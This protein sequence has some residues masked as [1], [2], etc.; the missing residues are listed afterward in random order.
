VIQQ[1]VSRPGW[2]SGNALAIVVTGSGRRT[3]WAYNGNA[4]LAPL[5]HIEYGGTAPPGD[6]PPVARLSVA[7]VASPPLTVTANG[8]A[9]T[10]TD[11]TP[12]ASYRF[13]FGDGTSAVTTSA[14]VTTATH[15]YASP[16]TYTVTLTA[17]DTGGLTSAPTTASVT[18]SAASGPNVAVYV[19]YYDTHHPNLTQPKPSPWRG[20]TNVVF[21]GTPDPG[22][23]N[24][25]DSSCLRIDNLGSGSLSVSAFVDMGSKTF[26]LWGTNTLPAGRTLI[27]AQTGFENFDGSDTSPA[28]CYGCNPNLCLTAVSSTR[29]VVQLTIGGVTTSYT[30][31]GQIL[32]T[33]GVDGAGCPYT[34]ERNDES[35][36][37]QRVYATA[38]A[39]AAGASHSE[40][41]TL[42]VAERSL[43]LASP[44]PNPTRGDMAIHFFNPRRGA[45][46][47][48]VYDPMGRLVKDYLDEV[49]EAGE[50]RG[51]M[52]ITGA[53]AGV[54]F[55]RLR[56][57]EGALSR[58]FVLVR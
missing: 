53:A 55:L 13:V 34:G 17:T 25:W 50:Y 33:H 8:S 39:Q 4:A 19:G 16:G 3:A 15:T 54:Y 21:V 45:V 46:R 7:Q 26:S 29:P 40:S 37:W 41:S 52:R 58:E 44:A 31:T 27:L 11:A 9:S 12:I 35:H 14:P 1:I 6:A 10:D 20:S 36:A 18:V 5:L 43:S 30:D 56:T 48:S 23:S 51:Q 42:P 32:N 2:A 47:L 38:P 57:P 49:I 28:G 24:E 22:T